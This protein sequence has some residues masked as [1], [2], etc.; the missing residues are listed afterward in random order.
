MQQL[1]SGGNCTYNTVF[2]THHSTWNTHKQRFH[3]RFCKL[4]NCINV[5]CQVKIIRD[6]SVV[7]FHFPER[8]GAYYSMIYHHTNLQD[9]TANSA[10]AISTTQVHKTTML[11]CLVRESESAMRRLFTKSWK[12][13]HT[14]C[15]W[16]RRHTHAAC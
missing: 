4:S 8:R 12:T 13:S 2:Y 15:A 16:M 14:V 11:I 10:R 6:H 1:H 3:T 7:S 5:T 9:S